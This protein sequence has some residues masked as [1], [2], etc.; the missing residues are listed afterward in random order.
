MHIILFGIKSTPKNS[1]RREIIRKTWLDSQRW[2]RYGITVKVVFLVG[3]DSMKVRIHLVNHKFFYIQIFESKV[4]FINL[5]ETL[6][7]RPS[8]I[9][10]CL[11]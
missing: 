10:T 5:S 3:H 6:K 4:N 1:E 7:K 9:K 2:K 11:L 8:F